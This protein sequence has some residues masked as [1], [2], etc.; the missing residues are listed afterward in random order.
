MA[1]TLLSGKSLKRARRGTGQ[2]FRAG[3]IPT[4]REMALW[5]LLMRTTRVIGRA[6]ERELLGSPVSAQGFA[7]LL[8]IL[9]Q[10]ANATPA[11]ISR[12]TVLEPNTISQQLTRMEKD[13]LITRVKDLE[14][15]NRVRI[16]VT[17]KGYR[18]FIDAAR[19]PMTRRIMSVLGE[20]EK[21]VLWR[22]LA[23]L[24][25]K[26]LSVLHVKN[27]EAY[28]PSHLEELAE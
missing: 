1:E 19:R 24:R 8:T 3:P 22:T 18:G 20:E 21:D 15:R 12:E 11:S 23:K 13:G 26:A 25:G 28:P 10:G 7:V 5:L 27:A 17:E 6:R 14:R 16:Q 4:T 9:R 2:G